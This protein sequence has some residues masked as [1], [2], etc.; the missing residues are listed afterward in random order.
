MITRL[1]LNYL[2]ITHICTFLAPPYSYTKVFLMPPMYL[3]QAPQCFS[4]AFQTLIILGVKKNLPCTSP[5]NFAP[6]TLKLCPVPVVFEMWP[7]LK[8]YILLG[9]NLSIHIWCPTKA[10][11]D[12]EQYQQSHFIF[13]NIVSDAT[14]PSWSTTFRA[15]SQQP[16]LLLGE[17]YQCFG[18]QGCG[19]L[20]WEQD[21]NAI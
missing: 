4:I 9:L 14:P 8:P 2:H 6:L 15:P 18:S 21:N 12:C 1:S 3:L 10:L 7:K 11:L 16:T 17:K 5:L 13:Q 19:P 20:C